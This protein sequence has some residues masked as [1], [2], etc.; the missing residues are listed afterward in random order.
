MSSGRQFRNKVAGIGWRAFFHQTVLLEAGAAILFF[1]SLIHHPELSRSGAAALDELKA[2]GYATPTIAEPVR[3]YPAKTEGSFHSALAGGWRPGVIY[4][5]GNPTGGFGPEVYLRHEL[6]H[7]ASYRTCGGRVPLWAEEASAMHFSGELSERRESRAPDE[8]MIDHLR[9]RIRIGASL[10]EKSYNTLARLVSV[11][12]WPNR[13]CAVSEEIKKLVTAP[14]ASDFSFILIHLFSGRILEAQGDLDS[15]YPPGSLLKIPYAASL[16]EA[17]NEAI[18][19]ELA[20]SDTARLLLRWGAVDLDRFRFLTSMVKKSSLGRDSVSKEAEKPG[21]LVV[22]SYLGERD[23]AGNFPFEANLKELSQ[24]LRASLLLAPTRFSGL[25]TNGFLPQ[26]TLHEANNT[27]KAILKKMRASCKTGTVSDERGNPIV[28]HLMVA[29]PQE[30]PL[31]LAVFRRQGT[32]GASTLRSAAKM[33]KKWSSRYT[34]SFG[35]VTVRLLTLTPRS[36]WEIV[37]ECSSRERQEPGGAKLRFSSCG[38]FKI[39]SSARGSRSERFVRG[40][41]QTLPDNSKVILK[42]DPESYA[43]AVLMAEGQDLRG[44]AAK[45]LRAVIFWNGVHGSHRHP[46]SSSLCDTTHCMVF[47]GSTAAGKG[48]QPSNTDAVLLHLLDQLT[49]ENR[50]DWLSFSKGGVDQWQRK[51]PIAEMQQVVGESTILDLRRERQRN[52]ATIVHLIYPE[53]EEQVPCELFRARLKLPSCP[54]TIDYEPE[55]GAWLFHGIGKGHG[56]GLSVERA[57]SLGR[58]GYNAAAIIKD[59]YESIAT[60]K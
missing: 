22:R 52:G 31:F 11:Y 30:D 19:E 58:S 50:L 45:A 55:D 13:R 57:R 39:L 41:L 33:L 18:G 23:R 59:A 9:A 15:A 38:W 5:R 24:V 4:V 49:R 27:H 46:D 16:T 20:R 53:S 56:Q 43:D 54:E 2:L 1:G 6:M 60:P 10:D 3:V 26:S 40:L 25:A 29:W 21:E 47:R 48:Q 42:T 51:V 36:S 35:Q 44:E 8:E 14:T 37:E 7:E 17:S 32:N 34:T 12:G 28:G